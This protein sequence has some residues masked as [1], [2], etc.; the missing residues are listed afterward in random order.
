M[1]VRLFSSIFLAKLAPAYMTVSS[2]SSI[3]FTSGVNAAKPMA[4]WSVAAAGGGAREGLT[5]GLAVDLKPIRVNGVSPGAILT[6]LFD[7]FAGGDPER[8]EAIKKTWGA[9]TLGGEIG[10]PEDTAEAYLYCMKDGFVT[11]QT[12]LTDG[13]YT[14]V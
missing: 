3:T 8:L 4:G 10:K 1:D 9:R 2:R 12:I 6:E 7:T 14:L 13:G 5:R 11:G